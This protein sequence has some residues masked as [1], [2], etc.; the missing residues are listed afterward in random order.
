MAAFPT[1]SCKYQPAGK[2]SDASAGDPSQHADANGR[3]L[4]FVLFFSRSTSVPHHSADQHVNPQLTASPSNTSAAPSSSSEFPIAA[5]AGGAV[6]GIVLIAAIVVVAIFLTRR[7]KQPKASEMPASQPTQQAAYQHPLT[8]AAPPML[9]YQSNQQ[10][11]AYQ[12]TAGAPPVPASVSPAATPFTSTSSTS[13]PDALF[14][15]VQSFPSDTKSSNLFTNLSPVPA[16]LSTASTASDPSTS[17]RPLIAPSTPSWG[18]TQASGSAFSSGGS[19]ASGSRRA[20][21]SAPTA[22]AQGALIGMSAAEV[23][24]QLMAMGVAPGLAAALEDHGVD[25]A[26]LYDFSDTD[27]LRMG[28]YQPVSRNIILRAVAHVRSPEW[29]PAVVPRRPTVAATAGQGAG[30]GDELP[31]YSS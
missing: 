5:V 25:G 6:G 28:I 29:T 11:T 22:A 31:Q 27:L 23:S 4:Y 24:D 16:S 19:S 13:K 26:R 7:H 10:R 21:E 18:G 30:G 2:S 17:K 9:T 20:P 12:M 3:R 1:R 14:P 15:G 8:A